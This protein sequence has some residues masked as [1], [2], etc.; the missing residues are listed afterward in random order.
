MLSGAA[1]LIHEVAWTRL[2][3]LV[4]GNTTFSI[5][6]VLA[7]FM[8]GLALGGYFGG[9]LADRRRDPL[10]VFAAFEALIG[11][12]CLAL[13]LL[14]DAVE[15]LYGAAYR[16]DLGFT[17]L[18]L[19]RFAFCGLLLLPP[20]TLM[21]ATLPA[22]TRW[23]VSDTQETGRHVGRLYAANTLGAAAGAPAHTD[24]LPRLEF[25]APRTALSNPKFNEIAEGLLQHQETPSTGSPRPA[26]QTN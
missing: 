20:A 8:A 1:G 2:L 19:L 7:V 14:I 10:R 3:R 5:A 6:T 16:A 22:L 15:P 9:R 23:F 13:P 25:T 17:G 4:M 21:G 11:L 12:Y 18:S 26:K 24:D